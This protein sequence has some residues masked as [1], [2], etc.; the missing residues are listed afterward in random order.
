MP[1][2]EKLKQSVRR[3]AHFSCCLC[4]ALGVEIHHIVPQEDKG[5]DTVENAAPLC[6]SCH[7]TYGANPQK[8]KFIKEARDLWCEICE[9]RYA[10]DPQQLKILEDALKRIDDRVTKVVADLDAAAEKIIKQLT[11]GDAFCRFS[12]EATALKSNSLRLVAIHEGQYPLYDLQARIVDLEKFDLLKGNLTWHNHRDADIIINL[13]T[14][15]PKTALL[16][17]TLPLQ[18]SSANRFN[19]F[20]TAR[21]GTFTQLLRLAYV[22][23]EWKKASK[24]IR[25]GKT[26][27]WKSD[28]DSLFEAEF[29]NDKSQ[30]QV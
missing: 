4:K 10:T 6:P 28:D 2:S 15:N 19:V 24:V 21:N 12:I 11:G 30:Q 16:G 17:I 25:D 18:G 13:G 5:P 22:D 1:F 14:L 20:F 3:R 23:G 27:F 26:L 9:R 8:R 7:E 29:K